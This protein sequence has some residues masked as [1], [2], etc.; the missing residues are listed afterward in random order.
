MT[1]VRIPP[2]QPKTLKEYFMKKYRKKETCRAF[3]F[4][5]E[6]EPGWFIDSCSNGWFTL[7]ADGAEAAY[8]NNN[9]FGKPILEHGDYVLK[10][11]IGA[12]YVL[13]YESFV[14]QYE[15]CE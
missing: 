11:Q 3:R 5:H 15:I 14:A 9:A 6:K 4:G 7:I 1:W 12:V 13:P 10:T 2:L 8:K